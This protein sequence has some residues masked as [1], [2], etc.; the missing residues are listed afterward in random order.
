MILKIV[1]HTG[2]KYEDEFSGALKFKLPKAVKRLSLE[3]T[4]D[5]KEST[6]IVNV[7]F[8]VDRHF[9]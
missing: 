4:T 6:S 7:H 2:Q 5:C 3:I 1:W 8:R 9:W